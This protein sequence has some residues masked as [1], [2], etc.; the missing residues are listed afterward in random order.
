MVYLMM[1]IILHHTVGRWS[2][3]DWEEAALAG[4]IEETTK[5]KLIFDPHRSRVSNT[6]VIHSILWSAYL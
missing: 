1:Q 3:M 5:A 6:I 4:G 2:I